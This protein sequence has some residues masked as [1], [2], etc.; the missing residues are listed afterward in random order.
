MTR[1]LVQLTMDLGGIWAT[2]TEAHSPEEAAQDAFTALA[3]IGG[4]TAVIMDAERPHHLWVRTCVRPRGDGPSSA[5]TR[6]SP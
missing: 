3:P 2:V 4:L 5:P 1:F 6:K